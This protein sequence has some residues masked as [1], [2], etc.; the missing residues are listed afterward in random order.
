MEPLFRLQNHEK[1]ISVVEAVLSMVSCYSDL[2]QHLSG[3]VEEGA[4]RSTSL[5]FGGKV[6]GWKSIFRSCQALEW[7]LRP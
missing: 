4:V 5:E 2:T 6:L 1:M 3:D 7:C